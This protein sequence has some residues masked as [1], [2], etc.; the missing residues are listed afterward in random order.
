VKKICIKFSKIIWVIVATLTIITAIVFGMLRAATPYLE[1]YKTNIISKINQAIPYSFNIDDFAITWYHFS[2]VI[3]LNNVVIYKDKNNEN[4]IARFESAYV[5][6]DLFDLVKTHQV[7]PNKIIIN[8][9][10]L[11]I[12]E[13]I[14]K[15]ITKK[16][17]NRLTSDKNKKIIRALSTIDEVVL[18]NLN[19]EIVYDDDHHQQLKGDLLVNRYDNALRIQGDINTLNTPFKLH[20]VS[21]VKTDRKKLLPHDFKAYF[22]VNSLDTEKISQLFTLTLPAK[23]LIQNGKIWVKFKQ[24]HISFIA[25]KAL[26]HNVEINNPIKTKKPLP[27]VSLSAIYNDKKGK[28]RISINHFSLIPNKKGI[29]AL[30]SI[31]K[32]GQVQVYLENFI[33]NNYLLNNFII[34]N[35][36]FHHYMTVL[37]PQF[38]VNQL[39]ADFRLH[40]KKISDYKAMF[41]LTDLS[42]APYKKIPGING[43]TAIINVNKTYGH[44]SI[45]LSNSLL[46]IPWLFRKSNT[47]KNGRANLSWSNDNDRL[48]VMLDNAQLV[49]PEGN[50]HPSMKLFINRNL[51]TRLELLA[52]ANIKGLTQKAVYGYLPV[53]IMPDDVV[54]W[55][56]Q[57]IR[58]VGTSKVKLI[59]RGDIEKFPFDKQEGLFLIKANTRNSNLHFYEGWPSIVNTAADLTFKNRAMDIDVS[60]GQTG[61]L[62]IINANAHIPVMGDDLQTTLYVSGNGQAM[63]QNGINYLLDSPLGKDIETLNDIT[64]KGQFDLNLNLK[65]PF[66]ENANINANGHA[67]IHNGT[68]NYKQ[69]P[70][71]LNHIDGKLYFDNEKFSSDKINAYLGKTPVSLKVSPFKGQKSNAT[72]INLSGSFSTDKINQYLPTKLPNFIK[73][74]AAMLGS[75]IIDPK[76]GFT[77]ALESDLKGIE[78]SL[79]APLGKKKNESSTFKL[80]IN[81]ISERLKQLL[82]TYHQVLSTNI[83]FQKNRQDELSLQKGLVTIGDNTK[84]TMPTKGINI[85]VNAKSVSI[86]PWLDWYKNNATDSQSTAIESLINSISLYAATFTLFGQSLNHFFVAYKPYTNHYVW[87]I[88]SDKVIGVIDVP[89]DSSNNNPISA[90]FNKLYFYT[91][92]QAKKQ[93]SNNKNITLPNNK[94]N[95]NFSCDDLRV[96]DMQLGNV[97]TK[98]RVAQD[99]TLLL[100]PLN[101]SSKNYTLKSK[102]SWHPRSNKT[103]LTGIL[104]SH[105]TSA[106]LQGLGMPLQFYSN[107]AKS[108]FDLSWNNFPTNFNA[109]TLNGSISLSVKDGK[110]AGLSK[111]TSTKVGLGT[112]ITALNL[113]SLPGRISHG[114][115]NDGKKGFSFKKMQANFNVKNG[116]LLTERAF[117]ESTVAYLSMKGRI[118]LVAK[119]LDLM[120]TVI[121]NITASLPVIATIAGGPVAGA[122]T[123]VV[124]KAIGSEVNKITQY[125]YSITGNWKKPIV[126]KQ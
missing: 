7:I 114:L 16:D 91:T 94:Y 61:G 112:I 48:T 50:I 95:I 80:I 18:K 102:L 66:A 51:P 43:V 41:K 56:D 14:I 53:G 32:N 123:W 37:K 103:T 111:S 126:R 69:I 46:K 13:K 11:S 96:N 24:Q 30:T 54:T 98:M 38:T 82:I 39:R 124:D 73:G 33:F 3:S 47:I 15:N 67:N 23:G 64:T 34:K 21:R 122:A 104:T 79:P 113:E 1:K 119:D 49:M 8:Q 116:N 4:P 57:A 55:L 93:Q 90:N 12:P 29:S 70:L 22:E 76:I 63:I 106:F 109:R 74:T 44:A 40:N 59:L 27:F 89:K 115:S 78:V 108:N 86:A 92:D 5:G 45:S 42:V 107:N 26:A 110:V 101:A 117:I 84:Q 25:V 85:A 121:P 52:D 19:L 83:Y 71:S 68:L 17:N 35:N 60:N 20:F 62:K 36:D 88:K 9:A 118:G 100:N 10:S 105:N 81:N 72:K 2:P 31:D 87:R 99:K 6:I 75:I 97:D 65:I 77:A 28:K 120:M 125:H 58:R